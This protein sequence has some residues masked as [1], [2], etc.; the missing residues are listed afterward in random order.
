MAPSNLGQPGPNV[1]K[2]GSLVSKSIAI[3]EALDKSGYSD[4]HTQSDS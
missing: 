2:L 3:S 4:G 1:F